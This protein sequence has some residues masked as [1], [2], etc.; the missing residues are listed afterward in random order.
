[1]RSA[2]PQKFRSGKAARNSVANFFTSSRP[3]RGACI[4][5][6][7]R[8][9]GAASSSTTAGFHGFP[10]NSV[11]QRRTIALFS[12]DIAVSSPRVRD[13][14]TVTGRSPAGRCQSTPRKRGGGR[15]REMESRDAHRRAPPDGRY[16]RYDDLRYLDPLDSEE[17]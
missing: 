8:M 2:V 1:M 3:R 4:E 9:S 16:K 10:Q 6:S 7:N 12:S 13:P 14:S 15:K 11:N 17:L 5:Y